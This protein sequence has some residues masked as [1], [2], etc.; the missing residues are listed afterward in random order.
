M[1]TGRLRAFLRRLSDSRTELAMPVAVASLLLVLGDVVL[2]ATLSRLAPT[3]HAQALAV[4]AST[5]R[6]IVGAPLALIYLATVTRRLWRS[7]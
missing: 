3:L 5:R 2:M 7:A 1:V 4:P 6:W